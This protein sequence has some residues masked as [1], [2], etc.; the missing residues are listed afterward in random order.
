M[1][2]RMLDNHKVCLII[3]VECEGAQESAD[4]T[5]DMGFV[6]SLKI[7]LASMEVANSISTLGHHAV[8]LDT[9]SVEAQTGASSVWVLQWEP[10]L[11]HPSVTCY[12]SDSECYCCS[13]V[14]QY[15]RCQSNQAWWPSWDCW[16]CLDATP[17]EWV[18]LYEGHISCSFSGWLHL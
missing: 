10:R 3:C 1:L 15:S 7:N 12:H 9:V 4:P 2:N 18:Q 13:H 11:P 17:W 6:Q 14:H 8:L 16:E 5:S